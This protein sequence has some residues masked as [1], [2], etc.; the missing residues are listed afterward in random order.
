MVDIT[1]LDIIESIS[2]LAMENLLEAQ[3][4]KRLLSDVKIEKT[5]YIR[6]PCVSVSVT[7]PLLSLAKERVQNPTLSHGRKCPWICRFISYA[8]HGS[9]PE[10]PVKRPGSGSWLC[11]LQPN[12]PGKHLHIPGLSASSV[13]RASVH[14]F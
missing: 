4:L 3:G 9:S 10:P 11:H 14:L 7:F 6:C 13:R 8:D 12:D 2:P 5:L 1:W